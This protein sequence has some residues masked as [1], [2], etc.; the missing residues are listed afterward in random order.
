MCKSHKLKFCQLSFVFFLTSFLSVSAQAKGGLLDANGQPLSLETLELL[1]SASSKF[2]PSKSKKSKQ[3]KG[4]KKSKKNTKSGPVSTP[5]LEEELFESLK[6]GKIQRVKYLLKKGVK[7]RFTDSYGT[8]PLRLA[9]TKGWA[10]MVVDLIDHGANVNEEGRKGLSLLHTAAARGLID[11]AKVLV[12]SGIHPSTRTKTGW[13]PLHVSARYGHWQLVQ[14]FLQQGVDP[15]A[16]NKQGRTALGLAINL[17]HQ[18][19]VKIL[20]RVTSVRSLD[21]ERMAN[22]RALRASNIRKQKNRRENINELLAKKRK[23]MKR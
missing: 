7:P 4:A 2:S 22:L 23:V 14:F 1:S 8:T 19:V 20:S 3:K 13:T 11:V 15:N 21:Q 16:K 10:S 12:K 17:R 9:T 18:G 6:A 5:A